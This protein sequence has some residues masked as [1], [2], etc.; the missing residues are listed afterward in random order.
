M[1]YAPQ[2]V[3]LTRE[4][5]GDLD[6]LDALRGRG[7]RIKTQ[8][9]MLR[10]QSM[11]PVEIG[12][13]N[14]IQGNFPVS[15]GINKIAQGLL[16]TYM[17]SQARDKAQAA[18]DAQKEEAQKFAAGFLGTPEVPGVDALPPKRGTVPGPVDPNNPGGEPYTSII[19]SGTWDPPQD[20]APAAAGDYRANAPIFG[21][22]EQRLETAPR[23]G[24]ADNPGAQGRDAVPA[25]AAIPLTQAQR[26][27]RILQG[28]GSTNPTIIRMA[29]H[30]SEQDARAER[31][32]QHNEV[33]RSN[34][35]V[36]AESRRATTDA[37]TQR[38]NETRDANT[39]RA[40]EQRDAKTQQT[41]DATYNRHQP[42]AAIADAGF[43]T[44]LA[45]LDTTTGLIADI[46]KHPKLGDV[47]APIGSVIHWMPTVTA[48]AEELQQK[49]NQLKATGSLGVLQ[50][51]K[52][53]GAS[54]G[55]VTNA[56]AIRLDKAF[57][58]LSL[59]TD[60]DI[61][62]KELGRLQTVVNDMR[63]RI[64]EQQGHA[65]NYTQ[66]LHDRTLDPTA[67]IYV[68]PLPTREAPSP[69]P[70]GDDPKPPVA[71]AP[72]PPPNEIAKLQEGHKTTFVNGQVWTLKDGKP[73]RVK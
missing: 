12:S 38:A 3:S 63:G 52:Q 31:E 2:S 28:M 18:A 11:S 36:V 56:D 4:A 10:E 46:I 19:D 33:L 14:G 54:L 48:A 9:E 7:N 16:A 1:A 55:S 51:L 45:N 23:Q 47:V 21:M 13:Y 60:P 37:N 29:M 58:S 73:V 65:R 25:Q 66:S 22:P 70:P 6:L 44:A 59:T 53:S 64:A 39:Q 8:Q 27:A 57:S 50:A 15:Q 72:L 35:N 30:L 61:F 20:A 69:N 49:I 71:S 26:T 41:N 24:A 17:D 68:I 67:P 34:A 43:N 62:K 5:G 32:R 42:K 40:N